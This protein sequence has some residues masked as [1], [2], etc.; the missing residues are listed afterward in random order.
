M[1]HLSQYEPSG[2]LAN[3]KVGIRRAN[4]PPRTAQTLNPLLRVEGLARGD[5]TWGVY[6]YR[7]H[8]ILYAR[9]NLCESCYEQFRQN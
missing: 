6:L 4:T 2:V 9:Y 7:V 8:L 5:L 1:C 3:A